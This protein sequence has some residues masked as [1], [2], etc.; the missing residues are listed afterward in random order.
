MPKGQPS[1]EAG[2]RPD[3]LSHISPTSTRNT[4]GHIGRGC[5]FFH[6]KRRSRRTNPIRPFAGY[7][8]T[9]SCRTSRNQHESGIRPNAGTPRRPAWYRAHITETGPRHSRPCPVILPRLLRGNENL[10]PIHPRAILQRRT[11]G[12]PCRDA[13]HGVSSASIHTRRL[14]LISS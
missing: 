13:Q 10:D 8:A 4:P 9:S 1:G 11:H 6:K 12:L 14:F 5:F 7:R 2:H 3:Y